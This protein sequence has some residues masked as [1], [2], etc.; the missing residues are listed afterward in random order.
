M[1][2]CI[3]T[4]AKSALFVLKSCP[5][6]WNRFHGS[7]MPTKTIWRDIVFFQSNE[8]GYRI[9]VIYPIICIL[10]LNLKRMLVMRVWQLIC[11]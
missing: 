6:S 2:I 5:D 1:R 4:E 7:P 8:Q 11:S 10:A 3:E 9:N